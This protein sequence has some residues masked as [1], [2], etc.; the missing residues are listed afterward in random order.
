MAEKKETILREATRALEFISED[1]LSPGDKKQIV[2]E[3]IEHFKEENNVGSDFDQNGR[4]GAHLDV[5]R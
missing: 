5:P 3:A 4:W 2:S 1:R